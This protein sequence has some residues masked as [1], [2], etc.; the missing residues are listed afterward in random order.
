MSQANARDNKDAI[1]AA[2]D[3]LLNQY[4]ISESKIA[5]KEEE[6]EKNKNQ[7]LLKKTVNYT[8]DNIINGMASLQLSFGSAVNGLADNL[9]IESN[10]LDEL[11]KVIAVEQEYLQQ[12]N[13]VRLV[14]DAL[15]IL[16]LE[17]QEKI[18]SLQAKTSQE[19]E[20]I[21]QEV[22]QSK[23]YWKKEQDEFEVRVKE[24]AELLAKEREEEE[25]DYQYELDRQRTIENDEYEE[26]QRLQTR[27]LVEQEAVNS[28]DWAEREKYLAD[29][30]PEFIKNQEQIDGFEAK[31][32]EEYNKAKGNA[33]KEAD[34][35]Y[36]VEAELQ[37]K[38][39]SG[40]QQGYELK[41]ESL[42]VVIERQT[43][44]ITEITAQLQEVNTQAQN[45]A[46]QAFQ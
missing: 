4:Q 39:W 8:A 14:A 30:K 1:L 25:A 44:Q 46:M 18:E 37:E 34:N 9:T 40:N 26:S 45:L 3:R 12:L 17:H 10:K 32:K 5:T 22:A 28:Q 13:Q 23:K 29:N 27:E 42:T 20:T 24:S 43:Q 41:I 21:E 38:E 19:K 11:Q 2:F 15:H 6:A 33:I 35:K 36:K 31:L 7:Q 16:N